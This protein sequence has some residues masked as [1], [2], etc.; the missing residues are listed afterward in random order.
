MYCTECYRVDGNGTV[1]AGYIYNGKSLC[2]IH[3]WDEIKSPS[4]ELAVV[5]PKVERGTRLP[6]RDGAGWMPQQATI[7]QIKEEFPHLTPDDIAFEHRQFLDW[8]YSSASRNAVKKDWEGTWRNWMRRAFK[9][10]RNQPV[11]RTN[12]D[13]VN[14]WLTGGGN[15]AAQ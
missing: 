11:R 6:G 12:D 5:K 8:A 13:K 4:K 15:A 10:Q 2:N 3:L 9:T 1:E 7:D 14:E